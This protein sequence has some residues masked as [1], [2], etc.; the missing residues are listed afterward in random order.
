MGLVAGIEE[1]LAR[2]ILALLDEKGQRDGSLLWARPL[3]AVMA[4][5]APK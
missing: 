2:V 4:R 5:L 3:D 1:T